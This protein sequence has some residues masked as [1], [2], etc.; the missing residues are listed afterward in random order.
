MRSERA[1]SS[2]FHGDY[3]QISDFYALYKPS[4]KGELI[5]SHI[6]GPIQYSPF[7]K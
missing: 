2:S 4:I 5:L 6:F 1:S 3:A 7:I